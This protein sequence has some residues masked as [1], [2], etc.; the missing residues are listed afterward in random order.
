[1]IDII[2]ISK[3][4]LARLSAM[5]YE[6]DG[7]SSIEQLIF[8]QKVQTKGTKLKD[9]ISEQELRL[10]FIEELRKIIMICF[11]PLK[12]LQLINLR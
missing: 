7:G 2:K 3:K 12:H 1:M 11:I 4:V 10:L 9:R 6:K 8:P 5:D